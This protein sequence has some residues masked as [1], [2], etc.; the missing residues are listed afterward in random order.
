MWDKA[1]GGTSTPARGADESL[2]GEARGMTWG[3]AKVEDVAEGRIRGKARRVR[4]RVT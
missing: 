4:T 2:T 1:G 3:V